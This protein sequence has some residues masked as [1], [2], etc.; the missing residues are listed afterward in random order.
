MALKMMDIRDECILHGLQLNTCNAECDSVSLFSHAGPLCSSL[1][2]ILRGMFNSFKSSSRLSR[3]LV[4]R[5]Y[6]IYK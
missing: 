4:E 5:V 1:S 6:Q 2:N 3:M